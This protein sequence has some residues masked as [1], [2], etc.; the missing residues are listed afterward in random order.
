ME[1]KC[2]TIGELREEI[3]NLPDDTKI[4]MQVFD[5]EKQEYVYEP[6][7]YIYVNSKHQLT[8]A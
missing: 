8:L 1:Q 5:W 4:I 3:K 7:E 6:I 2:M